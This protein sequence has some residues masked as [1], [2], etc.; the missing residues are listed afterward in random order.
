MSIVQVMSALDRWGLMNDL[1]AVPPEVTSFDSS[2]IK[3]YVWT[4]VDAGPAAP[5]VDAALQDYLGRQLKRPE[6]FAALR[7][8]GSKVDQAWVSEAPEAD[9]IRSG[10]AGTVAAALP[11]LAKTRNQAD[12]ALRLAVER[13]GHTLLAL[14]ASPAKA[15]YDASGRPNYADPSELSGMHR[16]MH[17]AKGLGAVAEVLVPYLAQQ[18]D[19]VAQQLAAL[20]AEAWRVVDDRMQVK[21][22]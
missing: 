12:L 8:P 11:R 5:D 14:Q 21:R 16:A 9:Q 1:K 2:T 18:S 10:S 20:L 15:F 22:R 13:A 7:T 19:P 3:K 17:E 6:L 4:L